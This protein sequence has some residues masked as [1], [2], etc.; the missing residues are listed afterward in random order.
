M[1]E[2]RY[3]KSALVSVLP[4]T[5]FSKKT[6]DEPYVLKEKKNFL[7]GLLDFLSTRHVISENAVRKGIFKMI[8]VS[9]DS[10]ADHQPSYLSLSEKKN[11]EPFG[12]FC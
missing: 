1:K 2:L 11:L 4:R 5:Q 10:N 12:T 3:E 7:S 8:C 9:S 6:V